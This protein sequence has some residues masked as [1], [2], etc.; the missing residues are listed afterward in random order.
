MEYVTI[1]NKNISRE[2]FDKLISLICEKK[3][4]QNITIQL[5]EDELIKTIKKSSKLCELYSTKDVSK[6]LKSKELKQTIKDVRKVLHKLHGMFNEVNFTKRNEIID[7]ALSSELSDLEF[8]EEIKKILTMHSSSRERLKDYVHIYNKI[9]SYINKIDPNFKL[10]SILD[11]GCGFNPISIPITKIKDLKY[12][13]SDIN[14][15]ELDIIDKFKIPFKNKYNVNLLTKQFN[16]LDLNTKDQNEIDSKINELTNNSN[17]DL[18]IIFKVLEIIELNK[19]HKISE[20]I[21]KNL[22]SKFIIASF[23]TKTMTNKRMNF[24]NRGWMHLMLERL[25]YEY[26]TFEEENELFFII[27]K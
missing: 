10:N 17:V 14:S 23:P 21:I 26:E 7:K 13:A 6:I 4:F 16:L 27:K 22:P 19:S 2:N 8:E 15:E 11:I 5:V 18:T 12:I 20:N 9:F 1:N 24:T 25:E 3:E